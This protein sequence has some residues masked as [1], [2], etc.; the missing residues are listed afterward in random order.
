MN[1]VHTGALTPPRAPDQFLEGL[2]VFVGREGVDPS[3]LRVHFIGLS[4]PQLGE[5]LNQYAVAPYCEMHGPVDY[6]TASGYVSSADVALLIEADLNDGI[7]LPAK[8]AEYLQCGRPVMAVGP[9][10]GTVSD[11]IGQYGGGGA[12]DCRS[13]QAIAEL[14]GAMYRSW[15]GGRLAQDFAIGRL[16]DRFT[17][18]RAMATF[19][20]I[21]GAVT[22]DNCLRT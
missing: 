12:A 4:S 7:F 15:R 6:S 14:L 10:N 22:P 1:I 9:R 5:K 17:E 20:E 16:R 11:L 3:M 8:F 13:P 19:A 2:S 21:V 18:S